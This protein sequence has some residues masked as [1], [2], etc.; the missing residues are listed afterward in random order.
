VVFAVTVSPD[1]R[2]DTLFAPFHWGGKSAANILTK[3]ALDPTSGMPEF[4]VCAVRARAI[5]AGEEAVR[6]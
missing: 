1:I 4:K 3:P 5:T 6:P 2:A